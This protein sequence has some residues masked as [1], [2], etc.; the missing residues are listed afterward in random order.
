MAIAWSPFIHG[1]DE[2]GVQQEPRHGTREKKK[3]Y[4]EKLPNSGEC[5][6][7]QNDPGC[8][9][10][11]KKSNG[12]ESKEEQSIQHYYRPNCR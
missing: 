4:N 8:K 9:L 10:T 12:G 1:D 3:T 7:E 11:Q 2:G 5:R 6:R